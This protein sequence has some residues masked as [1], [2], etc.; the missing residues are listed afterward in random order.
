M[1]PADAMVQDALADFIV[2]CKDEAMSGSV[3]CNFGI[4]EFLHMKQDQCADSDALSDAMYDDIRRMGFPEYGRHS[5]NVIFVTWPINPMKVHNLG[6]H[7]AMIRD[8]VHATLRSEVFIRAFAE[9]ETKATKEGEPLTMDYL[10]FFDGFNM[11]Q[12]LKDNYP[13]RRINAEGV[14]LACTLRVRE[15][16]DNPDKRDYPANTVRAYASAANQGPTVNTIGTN[17]FGNTMRIFE[18]HTLGQRRFDVLQEQN[19]TYKTRDD[20]QQA[21]ESHYQSN[22][23]GQNMYSG[24]YTAY[25]DHPYKTMQAQ[26]PPCG[27]TNYQDQRIINNPAGFSYQGG[28]SQQ[29]GE[30]AIDHAEDSAF[31]GVGGE[32]KEV[33]HPKPM[34]TFYT[35]QQQQRIPPT[36]NLAPTRS[37]IPTFNVPPQQTGIFSTTMH[38]QPVLYQ[39]LRYRADPRFARRS[40]GPD[41][42]FCGIGEKNR[43]YDQNYGPPVGYPAP[44]PMYAYAPP[45]AANESGL[46]GVGQTRSKTVGLQ[47]QPGLYS[48]AY[49]PPRDNPMATAGSYQGHRGLGDGQYQYYSHQPIYRTGPLGDGTTLEANR[50]RVTVQEG[51]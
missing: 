25:P 4:K 15:I 37:Q 11:Q 39:D 10:N 51:C 35:D 9:V 41:T 28:P 12:F 16:F 23:Y 30:R 44:V 48:T 43:P 26:A 1:A 13:D 17:K 32:K 3:R 29:R 45:V 46:C 21:G 49:G 34:G 47:V 20:R 22:L 2:R 7:S 31:C 33:E 14:R 40:S 36:Y 27:Q 8:L 24:Q 38:A 18:N 5:K 50:G 19:N 42:G 6:T